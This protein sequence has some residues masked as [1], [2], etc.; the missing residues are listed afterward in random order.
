MVTPLNQQEHPMSRTSITLKAAF[1][2][3]A[4]GFALASAPKPAAAFGFIGVGG[5]CPAGTH[6][7]Y[8][9]KYCWP[10]RSQICPSGTHLGY[11]GKYCWANRY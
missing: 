2:T 5:F 7:G 8:E 10:N 9:G 11:E 1:A 3:L 6:L 4:L